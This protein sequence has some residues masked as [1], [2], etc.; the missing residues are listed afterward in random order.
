MAIIAYVLLSMI[1]GVIG[2]N[3]RIGFWGVL[4]TSLLFTPLI[5]T[6]RDFI[7]GSPASAGPAYAIAVALVILFGWWAV[8]GMRSAESA[9]G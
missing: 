5:E 1:A 8:R 2:R 9:G 6:G 4:T 7:S 3:T